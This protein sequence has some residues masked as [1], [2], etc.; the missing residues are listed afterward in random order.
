M[1]KPTLLKK[2]K[3]PKAG[4]TNAQ[5]KKYLDRLD[6]VEKENGRRMRDYESAKK[7]RENLKK[8]IANSPRETYPVKRSNK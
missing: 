4:A 5:M 7:T 2:P 3:N 6:Y 1:K 8:K